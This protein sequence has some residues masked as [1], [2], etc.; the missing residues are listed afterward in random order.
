[1]SRFGRINEQLQETTGE[2]AVS[3]VDSRFGSA[4]VA[5]VKVAPHGGLSS[6]VLL[7]KLK[8]RQSDTASTTLQSDSHIM[9]DVSKYAKLQTEISLFFCLLHIYQSL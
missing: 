1:M 6:N 9:S 2:E 4:S 8:R 5:G 3:K 7:D